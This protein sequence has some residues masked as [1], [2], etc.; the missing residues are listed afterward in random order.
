MALS[1]CKLYILVSDGDVA[2][3]FLDSVILF[4][5]YLISCFNVDLLWNFCWFCFVLFCLFFVFL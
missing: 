3:V 2:E 4:Y 1:G 5:V